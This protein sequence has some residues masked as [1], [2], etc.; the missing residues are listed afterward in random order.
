MKSA[1]GNVLIAVEETTITQLASGLYQDIRF[2]KEHKVNISGIVIL[3]SEMGNK[4]ALGDRFEGYPRRLYK[5]SKP[6]NGQDY[7]N[8]TVK[9][10]DKVYFYYLTLMD[11]ANFLYQIGPKKVFKVR[12]SDIFCS[13]RDGEIIM[14]WNYVL[15]RPYF[16]ENLVDVGVNGL[17]GQVKRLQNGVELVTNLATKPQV[18][19]G[20]INNIGPGIYDQRSNVK[21]DD[22]VLLTKDSEF[23]NHI[24]GHDFWVFKH[25]DILAVKREEFIF[26]AGDMVLIQTDRK[27]YRGARMNVPNADYLETPFTGTVVMFGPSTEG[28][29]RGDKVLYAR[30]DMRMLMG[31]LILIRA[32]NIQCHEQVQVD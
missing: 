1:N 8:T 15:G 3:A 24:E 25:D 32:A 17:K 18:D 28:L 22:I 6:Y 7:P 29:K 27:E 30:K 13:V 5:R 31:N 9:V 23:I 20:V 16:G 2:N 21:K 11:E 26:P 10:G 14:N 4:E 19:I 12:L